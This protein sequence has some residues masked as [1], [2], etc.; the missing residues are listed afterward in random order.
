M[1]KL[2]LWMCQQPFSALPLPSPVRVPTIVS[3]FPVPE[4]SAPFHKYDD[5]CR[6]G[7]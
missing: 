5:V 6:W 1:N 3:A 7:L 4:L 2:I